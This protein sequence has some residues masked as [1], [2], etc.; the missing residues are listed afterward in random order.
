MNGNR[1]Q[2]RLTANNLSEAYGLGQRIFVGLANK[3]SRRA[4][5][6]RMGVAAIAA[7]AVSLIDISRV[8]AVVENCGCKCGAGDSC[9]KY[10]RDTGCV[11]CACSAPYGDVPATALCACKYQ[12]NTCPSGT[13]G[14]G[15][16]FTCPTS[17]TWQGQT[18][19]CD[20]T[21]SCGVRRTW[22]RG[23]TD[24][25][26]S[27]C[28]DCPNG[29]CPVTCGGQSVHWCTNWGAYCSGY[30]RCVVWSCSNCMYCDGTCTGCTIC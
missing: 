23:F 11:G 6:H 15:A 14:Y 2:E 4:F 21:N 12:S 9:Y 16:W 20:K 22:A 19:N 27:S 30:N 28:S 13:T 8:E 1:L 18:M 10:V 3:T 25:C 17:G 24:C 29:N 5:L 26:T 7:S